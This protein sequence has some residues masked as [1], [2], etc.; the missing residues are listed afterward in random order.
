M[1][2]LVSITR[3]TLPV[4][5]GAAGDRLST[6]FLEFLAANIRNSHTRG[7]YYQAEEKFLAWCASAGVA[8]IAAI[9]PVHVAAWIEAST[10]ELA[11]PE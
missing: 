4:L 10:R 8:S 1:N 3:G 11:A 7:A 6:P 2:R 9:Q 5:V